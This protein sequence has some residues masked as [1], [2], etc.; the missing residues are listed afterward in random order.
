MQPPAEETFDVQTLFRQVNERVVDV[1]SNLGRTARIA[2]FVC[3]CRDPECSEHLTLSVAAVRRDPQSPE[4]A[5]GPSGSHRAGLRAHGRGTQGVLGGGARQDAAARGVA[6]R[7]L[8]RLPA[9]H[10]SARVPPW[11]GTWHSWA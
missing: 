2:D 9:A 6:G 1:N 7:R 8:N 4:P 3:E 11:F 10:A 5:H